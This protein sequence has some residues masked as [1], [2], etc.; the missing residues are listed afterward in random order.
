[1]IQ[2]L[3][4]NIQKTNAPIVVGLDPM[5]NYI[6]KQVQEKAFKEYG[7][8]FQCFPVF[9]KCFFLHLFWDIV[10]HRV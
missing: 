8:T 2:K 6:P 7:E 1:M 4:A 10:Q 3:I 5:L 9:F